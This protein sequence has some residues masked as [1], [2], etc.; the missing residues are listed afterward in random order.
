MTALSCLD[1]TGRECNTDDHDPESVM[2][3]EPEEPFTTAELDASI[4]AGLAKN[5][6][7]S[8]GLPQP[9]DVALIPR[10]G[11]NFAFLL[12]YEHPLYVTKTESG[13]AVVSAR[14]KNLSGDAYVLPN[15]LCLR[16]PVRA[17]QENS[18]PLTLEERRNSMAGNVYASQKGL[19][20]KIYAYDCG[21]KDS[22]S[23]IKD[24]KKPFML[25]DIIDGDDLESMMPE[26]DDPSRQLMIKELSL[27]SKIVREVELPHFGVITA[28]PELPDRDRPCFWKDAD[29][30]V[31]AFGLPIDA[32]SQPCIQPAFTSSMQQLESLY[33]SFYERMTRPDSEFMEPIIEKMDEMIQALR[34]HQPSTSRFVLKH[35]DFEM[36]NVMAERQPDTDTFKLTLIDWDMIQSK[37]KQ[38]MIGSGADIMLRCVCYPQDPEECECFVSMLDAEQKQNIRKEAFRQLKSIHPEVTIAKL[39]WCRFANYLKGFA[40]QILQSIV[41][42][43]WNLLVTH[44]Q[45]WQMQFKGLLLICALFQS[46]MT[47]RQSREEPW[48]VE[49]DQIIR[50]P[51]KA[52]A[53]G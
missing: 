23:G 12:A 36:R 37:E 24:D 10:G 21:A 5:H 2:H 4:L 1:T 38:W 14:Y 17:Y 16:V 41:M 3:D 49:F 33:A 29:P 28:H 48:P 44:G 35:G 50:A 45:H 9:H 31:I 20:P 30:K 19:G 51:I 7:E 8:V 47:L 26:L 53:T 15:L 43:S 25:M 13:V 34:K 52:C 22:A 40:I 18:L 39:V 6:A 46:W 42:K 32:A 27:L 11:Y